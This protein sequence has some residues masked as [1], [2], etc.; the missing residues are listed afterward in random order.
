[1]KFAR[2]TW[3]LA[4]IGLSLSASGVKAGVI[5]TSTGSFGNIYGGLH[6]D[7]NS[8]DASFHATDAFLRTADSF[9]L[10]PG[11][12]SFNTVEFWGQYGGS[13]PN[14]PGMAEGRHGN[15]GGSGVFKEFTTAKTPIC[16]HSC[17]PG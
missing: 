16:R 4:L 6:S 13:G 5:F 1:M 7:I 17:S 8:G 14:P 10:K 12:T 2:V 9:S 15:C 11:G 3:L